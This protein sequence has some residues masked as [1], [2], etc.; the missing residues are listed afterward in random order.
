MTATGTTVVPPGPPG[1][2]GPA[3]PAVPAVDSRLQ[4]GDISFEDSYY[5]QSRPGE[6]SGEV[7]KLSL[8]SY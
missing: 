1:P 4:R 6:V 8:A 7:S 3:V 5:Y 2:P